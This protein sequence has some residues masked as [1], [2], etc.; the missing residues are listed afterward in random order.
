MA[1][2]GKGELWSVIE[3]EGRVLFDVNN[4]GK[5]KEGVVL[6]CE[7]RTLEEAGKRVAVVK[8]DENLWD[9]GD[10]GAVEET[11]GSDGTVDRIYPLLA[12]VV[13]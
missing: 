5:C 11:G 10:S 6:A 9:E 3:V 4:D 1:A 12:D 13:V 8:L 2:D 7:D